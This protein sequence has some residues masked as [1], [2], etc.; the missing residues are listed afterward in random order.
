MAAAVHTWCAVKRLALPLVVP[1]VVCAGRYITYFTAL[2]VP[3]SANT[4]GK[5]IIYAA[6]LSAA[7]AVHGGGRCAL[8]S[9]HR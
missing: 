1:V 5:F 3:V 2:E 6:R 4:S 7:G 9:P 8:A